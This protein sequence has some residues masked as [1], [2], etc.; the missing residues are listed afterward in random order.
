MSSTMECEAIG[1]NNCFVLLMSKRVIAAASSGLGICSTLESTGKV[2]KSSISGWLLQNLIIHKSLMASLLYHFKIQTWYMERLPLFIF[3]FTCLFF[4][5]KFS[6]AIDT[7]SPNQTITGGQILVSADEIFELG[8]FSLGTSNKRYLGILFKSILQ[9][10]VVWVANR[11]NPLTNSSGVLAIGGDGN[12]FLLNQTESVIWS[13]NSSIVPNVI[14][15][16]RRRKPLLYWS[17]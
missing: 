13:S 5:S 15:V 1:L 16:I 8:F 4:I 11:N 17:S 12:I 7:I 6:V 2:D 14:R 9:Q 10:T 3:S